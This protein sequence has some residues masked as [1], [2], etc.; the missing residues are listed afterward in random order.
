ML[1]AGASDIINVT[2]MQLAADP[3]MMLRAQ[4]NRFASPFAP[5]KY[6]LFQTALPLSGP[7]DGTV[8]LR[9][10]PIMIARL[11]EQNGPGF[12]PKLDALAGQIIGDVSGEITR[13]NLALVTGIIAGYADTHG[14]PK[15]VTGLWSAVTQSALMYALGLGLLLGAGASYWKRRRA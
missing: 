7:V 8:A 15:P 1:Q 3:A 11:I 2:A 9:V 4:V 10:G 5:G 6:R 12:D 14:L 13:A